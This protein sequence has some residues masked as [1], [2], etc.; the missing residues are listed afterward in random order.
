MT[1]TT[2]MTTTNTD[3]ALELDHIESGYGEVQVLWGLSLK[4]RAGK[5]ANV[6]R[7]LSGVLPG[8]LGCWLSGGFGVILRGL[9][10]ARAWL[11]RRKR[12]AEFARLAQ[13][14]LLSL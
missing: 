9:G 8:A 2:T 3:V 13:K 14:G 10:S 6:R 12:L 4:A 5:R 11:R 7:Y 1:T